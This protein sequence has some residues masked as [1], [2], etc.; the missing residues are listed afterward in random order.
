MHSLVHGYLKGVRRI[1]TTN[2]VVPL[3]T[4]TTVKPTYP[5][6]IRPL[7]G[8]QGPWISTWIN[9]AKHFLHTCQPQGSC[10]F[11]VSDVTPSP[12]ALTHSKII[13]KGLEAR[14]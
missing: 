4:L 9:L 3:R 2:L 14:Q 11:S 6:A 12:I 1:T 10:Y 8:D 5:V 13:G 7:G